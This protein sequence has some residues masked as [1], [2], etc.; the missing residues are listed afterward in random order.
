MG[1]CFCYSFPKVQ[2]HRKGCPPALHYK[3]QSRPQPRQNQTSLPSPPF[4]HIRRVPITSSIPEAYPGQ[5]G[6]AL[7]FLGS[8]PKAQKIPNSA[9]KKKTAPTHFSPSPR[10]PRKQRG[11]PYKFPERRKFQVREQGGPNSEMIAKSQRSLQSF[12]NVRGSL[13]RPGGGGGPEVVNREL[14]KRGF[15]LMRRQNPCSATGQETL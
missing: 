1:L 9:K 10:N 13:N 4:N 3:N 7:F 11:V 2:P 6:G 8:T 15:F 12:Y 5:R 14:K